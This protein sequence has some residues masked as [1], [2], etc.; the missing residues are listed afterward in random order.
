[1]PYPTGFFA[2]GLDGLID[3]PGAGWKGR[4]LWSTFGDR[5]PFH[6]EGGKGTLH[7]VVKFQLRPD[8]LA[9]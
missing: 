1:V 9:H 3:N 5:T 8:L 2:Q 6:N 7:K 4:A